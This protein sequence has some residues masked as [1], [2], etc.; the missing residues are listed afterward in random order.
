MDRM[1]SVRDLSKGDVSL[2]DML[3][4]ARALVV[5]NGG[6]VCI[7]DIQ[8]PSVLAV[9][10]ADGAPASPCAIDPAQQGAGVANAA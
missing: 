3:P 4:A 9:D 5:R 2:E 10:S 1:K 6:T 8:E 7:P